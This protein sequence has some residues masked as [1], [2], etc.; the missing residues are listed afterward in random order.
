MNSLVLILSVLLVLSMYHIYIHGPQKRHE[1]LSRLLLEHETQLRQEK[2]MDVRTI[3]IA[4]SNQ[5][6]ESLYSMLTHMRTAPILKKSIV[7]KAIQGKSETASK[8]V[9]EITKNNLDFFDKLFVFS[10]NPIHKYD[11]KEAY[12][13]MK[14]LMN[15][16]ELADYAG[17]EFDGSLLINPSNRETIMFWTEGPPF[18]SKLAYEL[19]KRVS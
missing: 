17:Y 3:E 19:L 11:A 10:Y 12:S 15:M 4:M 2:G 5:D 14:A 6:P 8:L 13:D 18:V 9:A 16:F 1:T 7:Q